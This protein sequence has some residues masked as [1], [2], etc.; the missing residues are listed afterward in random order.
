MKSEKLLWAIGEIDES[1]AADAANLKKGGRKKLYRVAIAAVA[2]VLALTLAVGAGAVDGL[3][4]S[5]FAPAFSGAD[6]EALD[7]EL[8]QRMGA[9][10]GTS[11]AD[12]GITVTLDS[13][14]RDRYNVT[15]VFTL[16]GTEAKEI[17]FD[18]MALTIGGTTYRGPSGA[19]RSPNGD[20]MF[21]ILNWTNKEP[22]PDGTAEIVLENITTYRGRALLERH[23]PGKWVLDFDVPYEDMTVE[24]GQDQTFVVDGMEGT[25]NRFSLSPL[26]IRMDFAV[27]AEEGA[28]EESLEERPLISE[29]DMVVA[30]K[31]G[32]K[33]YSFGHLPIEENGGFSSGWM[34]SDWADGQLQCQ[35]GALFN[36]PVS[37]E[38]IDS[39]T[40]EGVEIYKAQS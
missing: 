16:G 6:S 25:V 34:D 19:C 30:K 12:N 3:V 13:I 14:I 35:Y 2:A 18:D 15:A 4:D 29:L 24:L 37:L 27:Q 22:I 17:L 8:L 23:I 33:L 7:L 5:V 28:L 36:Q 9:P 1:L 31:D 40:I 20:D 21:I 32:T 11:A 26:S 10:V 39:I 38:E